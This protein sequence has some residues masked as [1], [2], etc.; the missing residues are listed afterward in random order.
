MG[1]LD[2]ASIDLTCPDCGHKTPK[3]IGWLRH[4]PDSFECAGCGETVALDYTEPGCPGLSANAAVAF[5]AVPCY[6]RVLLTLLFAERLN[7]GDGLARCF[8]DLFVV[9][10]TPQRLVGNLRCHVAVIVAADRQTRR[11]DGINGV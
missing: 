9:I 10:A 2:G 4:E 11:H 3:T 6:S 1:I 7:I 8:M 5:T